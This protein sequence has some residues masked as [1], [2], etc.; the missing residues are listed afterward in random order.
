MDDFSTPGSV[1]IYGI[2]PSEVNYIKPGKR[3]MSSMAPTIIVNKEGN[4]DLVIGSAGGSRITTAIANTIINYYFFKSNE[5]LWN[6]FGSKRLHHQLIPNKL[7][8]EKGFDENIVKELNTTF[9]HPIEMVTQTIGFGALVGVYVDK[10]SVQS[11]YDPRRGGSSVV[12]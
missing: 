11:A 10:D 9:K 1:N 2:P 8:F 12:F 4:V 5:S 6:N 7:Y 3:P